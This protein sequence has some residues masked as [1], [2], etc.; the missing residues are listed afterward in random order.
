MAIEASTPFIPP[1]TTSLI[2]ESKLLRPCNFH[3]LFAAVADRGLKAA[4]I[5]DHSEGIGDGV[6]VVNDK[7]LG[8]I[9]SV[10]DGMSSEPPQPRA[11]V[12]DVNETNMSRLA[13][14]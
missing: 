12:D 8:P 13:E 10:H 4:N 3:S 6:F 5:E 2:K 14:Q 1:M 9:L 11:P 7:N